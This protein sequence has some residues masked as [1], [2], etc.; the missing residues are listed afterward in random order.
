M[1]TRKRHAAGYTQEYVSKAIGQ[2]QSYMAKLETG[3]RRLD[4]V[5]YIAISKVIGFDPAAELQVLATQ[6]DL[7]SF[8]G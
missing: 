4:V 5:E 7:A 8:R 6:F 3:Q 2:H 1:I